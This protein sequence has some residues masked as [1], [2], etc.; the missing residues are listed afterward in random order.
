MS[1]AVACAV[2][3][4]G[5]GVPAVPRRE[6][7]TFV[8]PVVLGR[9]SVGLGLCFVVLFGTDLDGWRHAV[10]PS[11]RRDTWSPWNGATPQ[12]LS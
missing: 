4:P 12:L 3:V 1:W 5:L 8:W 7:W 2:S 10:F 11:A 9:A 6:G